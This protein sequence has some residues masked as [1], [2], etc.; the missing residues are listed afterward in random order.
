M[1]FVTDSLKLC[2]LTRTSYLPGS[3]SGTTYSP[4]EFDRAVRVTFVLWF[5]TVTSAPAIAAPDGSVTVPRIVLV[6]FCAGSGRRQ[7]RTTR[8]TTPMRIPV[9][10]DFLRT[11]KEFAELPMSRLT[12]NPK[13]A[14]GH[15]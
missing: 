4:E 10:M 8:A 11:G 3:S 12:F 13:A 15:R 2:C 9:R 5:L 6:T 14:A 7:A 1:F